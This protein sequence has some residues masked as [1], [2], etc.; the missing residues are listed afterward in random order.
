MIGAISRGDNNTC[1]YDENQQRERGCLLKDQQGRESTKDLQGCNLSTRGNQ[2]GIS[3]GG[4][5]LGIS[6]GGNQ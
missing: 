5:Q 1:N 6:T 2:L 3:T 4:N